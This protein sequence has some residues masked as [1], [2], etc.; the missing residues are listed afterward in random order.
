MKKNNIYGAAA[1]ISLFMDNREQRRV[2]GSRDFNV[3]FLRGLQLRGGG[4]RHRR[5][6]DAVPV[7]ENAARLKSSSR[8]ALY[9]EQLVL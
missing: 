3:R 9:K 4:V 5:M 8:A 6:D 7:G 2:R 1:I